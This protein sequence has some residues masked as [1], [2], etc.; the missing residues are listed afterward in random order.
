MMEIPIEFIGVR[1]ELN[2]VHPKLPEQ[3]AGLFH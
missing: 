1:Q 2:A 3:E